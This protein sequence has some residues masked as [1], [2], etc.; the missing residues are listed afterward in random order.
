LESLPGILFAT[1]FMGLKYPLSAA[2][3]GAAWVVG[4]ILYTTGYVAGNRYGRGGQLAPLSGAVLGI[5]ATWA[6]VEMILGMW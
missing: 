6:D 3:L 2:G 1:V 5:G 4:R